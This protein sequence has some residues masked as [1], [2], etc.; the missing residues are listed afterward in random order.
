M[1]DISRKQLLKS[2]AVLDRMKGSALAIHSDI[3]FNNKQYT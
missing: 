1:L 3:W 2:E